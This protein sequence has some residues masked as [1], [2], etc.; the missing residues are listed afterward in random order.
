MWLVFVM[1]KAFPIFEPFN[2][3]EDCAIAQ[4]W[5]RWIKLLKNLFFCPCY[6][7][8]RR[9]REL[10]YCSGHRWGFCNSQN[11]VGRVLWTEEECG[12]W[13]FYVSA[14][15]AKPRW[16]HKCVSL[17][18]TTVG[19]YTWIY[20]FGQ[21]NQISN[22]SVVHFTAPLPKSW[23]RF[24]HDTW[25]LVGPSKSIESLVAASDR[26]RIPWKCQ[27]CVPLEAQN[28]SLFWLWRKLATRCQGWVSCLESKVQLLPKILALYAV[29]SRF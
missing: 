7:V 15:E 9:D 6:L 25:S 26:L 22:S 29:L 19:S 18:P 23:E 13:Y 24:H 12:I 16:N 8:I 5:R 20:W 3:H 21:G 14:G 10:F 1:A 4:R 11:E 27:C 2:I 17:S 28:S